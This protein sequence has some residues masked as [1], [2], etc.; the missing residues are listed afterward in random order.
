MNQLQVANHK[1][2]QHVSAYDNL[3]LTV[4]GPSRATM[5]AL[6]CQTNSADA[7]LAAE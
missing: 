5:D 6:A 1:R 2:L 7:S 3:T 4:I